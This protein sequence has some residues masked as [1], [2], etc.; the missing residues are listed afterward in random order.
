MADAEP[1]FQDLNSGTK[2]VEERHRI[3]EAK[4]ETWLKAN[5]EGY[6]G[7]LEVR[8]FKGGQSNPTYQLVTPD[9]KYVL[10]R[11]PPGKLLPSAH[12]VDR[13]FKVISGLNKV[14]FPVAKAYALCEDDS[15]LGTMFYV[16]DNVEG[17]ILWDLTLPD[18]QPA[19]RRAIYEAKIATLAQLHN[20]DYEAIG[21]GDYGR[22]G[23]YFAR[24]IDRWTK[25]YKASETQSIPSMD[26]LI[27]WLPQ[28]TP[29]DDQTSIVHGDYRLDN[30]IL[31]PTEPRVVAVLDWELS[32]LGNPLADFSYLLMHWVMPGG[33]RASLAGIEDF[34]AWGIPTVEEAVAQYCRLTGRDGLPE[35]NWYFAYNMFRLAGICQGI[36]GRIRDGTAASAHAQTMEARVPALADAALAFAKKA[37]A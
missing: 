13:E 22:P 17:R 23:N 4:L 31:H 5:V 29:T 21:L 24:Q 19:E 20:V 12:A 28:T 11:K 33:E 7:P 18:S 9:R 16:M 1:T 3:D 27:E 35:L 34:A 6:A 10:R 15:V 26:R 8:Q 30:M 37:G 25:Q 2:P 14:N 32:T 36:V